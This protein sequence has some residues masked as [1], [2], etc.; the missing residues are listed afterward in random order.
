MYVCMCANRKLAG[1]GCAQAQVDDEYGPPAAVA[2]QAGGGQHS[3]TERQAGKP[4]T[5][6]DERERLVL[7][8]TT[9]GTD[10]RK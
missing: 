8:W 6:C 2:G 3:G 1:F 7:D 4:D 9:I 5:P 10:R